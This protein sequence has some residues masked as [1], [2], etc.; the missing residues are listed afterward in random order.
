MILLARITAWV[1][2]KFRICLQMCLVMHRNNEPEGQRL[3][4]AASSSMS[5]WVMSASELATLGD[6]CE[7]ACCRH[8]VTVTTPGFE[9]ARGSS[10]QSTA[11]KR[12]LS[13]CSAAWPGAIRVVYAEPLAAAQVAH[14]C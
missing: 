7:Y 11:M 6:P 14:R 8:D 4:R 10:D 5:T 3:S 13:L 9:H 2:R 1:R 12:S